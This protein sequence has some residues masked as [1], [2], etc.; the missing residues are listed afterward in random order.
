MNVKRG[1]VNG[2]HHRAS[3]LNNVEENKTK[4][5][6]D[7]SKTLA[8]NGYPSHIT[9]KKDRSNRRNE[10]KPDAT[11]RLP[12]IEGVSEQ[13]KRTCKK[14]NLRCVFY[15]R[16]TLRQS[17]THVKPKEKKNSKKN[18]IYQI[19]CSC[20]KV[21][22]G[23]TKRPL[24]VRI[25]EHRWATKMREID[26][27]KIANHAWGEGLH[28]PDWEN[29]KILDQEENAT[30]RKIKETAYMMI[31]PHNFGSKSIDIHNIWRPIIKKTLQ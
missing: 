27:S 12:Y 16:P 24:E 7:I 10:E 20:G 19:P 31:T 6:Q 21:Y 4:E 23:E 17:L 14:F 1:I 2:L 26:R 8:R 28:R 30:Q 3:V 18:S 11:I 13:I 22:V 29:T 15:S 25:N 5:L 9:R